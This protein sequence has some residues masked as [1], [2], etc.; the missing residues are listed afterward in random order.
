[1]KKKMMKG[2]KGRGWNCKGTFEEVFFFFFSF[3]FQ[4][5]NFER[6]GQKP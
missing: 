3:S 2:R 1:M 6:E 5:M 4:L